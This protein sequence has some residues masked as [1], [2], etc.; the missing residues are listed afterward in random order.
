MASFSQKIKDMVRN[1]GETGKFSARQIAIFSLVYEE[2]F[3]GS[4]KEL[5]KNL[6]IS[7]PAVTKALNRLE[8]LGYLKRGYHQHDKRMIILNQTKKGQKYASQLFN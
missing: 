7:R 4:V 6:N 8:Y 1:G 3:P 5:S 2:N